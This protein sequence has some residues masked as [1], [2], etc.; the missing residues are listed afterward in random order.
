MD[1]PIGLVTQDKKKRALFL[2]EKKAK[3]IASYHGQ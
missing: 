1:V 3:N 2:L